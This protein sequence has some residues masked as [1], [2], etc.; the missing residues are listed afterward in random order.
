MSRGF[1]VF[2][3]MKHDSASIIGAQC[4]ILYALSCS[5]MDHY[6]VSFTAHGYEIS[7]DP[8]GQ[9]CILLNG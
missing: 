6:H 8:Q 2:A 9:F 5:V 3:V 4:E 1:D 7:G